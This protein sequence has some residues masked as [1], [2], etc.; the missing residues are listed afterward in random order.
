MTIAYE[1]LSLKNRADPYPGFSTLRDSAPIHWAG[2]AEMFCLSRYD[3]VLQVLQDPQVF[4]SQA[5]NDILTNFEVDTFQPR[6][7]LSILRFLLKVRISPFKI[8]RSGTLI[9]LDPPLHGALRGVANRGFSPRRIEAW[10]KRAQEIT[11]EKLQKLDRTPVFDVVQDLAI[12][13]P[14]TLIAEIL[15]VEPERHRDFKHWTDTFISITSGNARKNPLQDGTL[16]IFQNLIGYFQAAVRERRRDPRDDLISVLVDPSRAGALSELEVVNFVVLLMVA[17]SETTTNLIG[18][19]VATL[20]KRPALLE[21]VAADLSLIPNLIEE[22]LRFESPVQVV[23]RNTTR[24]TELRG[25]RIAKGSVLALLLGSANRDERR[26]ERADIFDIDRDTR[27]HLGFGFGTH[28]CLGSSLARLEARVALTALLPR[29]TK[30][31]AADPGE[32]WIESFL[33]RGRR[34]LP[35]KRR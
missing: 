35:L 2:D 23:F 13:L 20:M 5:M 6:Y 32:E 10:E 18:N 24:D 26:F 30:M 31:Q 25:T 3:D 22:T 12:P 1:P 29:L 9:S 28:F 34:R 27:G 33:I 11:Q 21:H 17:G 4:S 19:A 15:G 7:L 16:D 8:Q 14:V